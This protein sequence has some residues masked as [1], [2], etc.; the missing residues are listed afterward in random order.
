[1][2]SCG[3]HPVPPVRIQKAKVDESM[4]TTTVV[5]RVS[6]ANVRKVV[7]SPGP[8]CLPSVAVNQGDENSSQSTSGAADTSASYSV[9]PSVGTLENESLDAGET[10]GDACHPQFNSPLLADMETPDED[11]PIQLHPHE[12][13]EV[14]P[15][16]VNVTN[17]F[18][19][20]Q[21]DET[22]EVWTHSYRCM[23][24]VLNILSCKP[25]FLI[26]FLKYMLHICKSHFSMRL[27]YQPVDE[28][29]PTAPEIN[30][31][32]Y[33]CAVCLDVFFQPH[34]CEPCDHIFCAP[35][36]KRLNGSSR[37]GAICPLC[38][39]VIIKCHSQPGKYSKVYS[40]VM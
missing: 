7:V 19:V 20:L 38:R 36:L 39:E 3:G 16:H 2:C 28:E 33:V 40:N 30:E 15:N 9:S 17:Q 27:Y 29:E 32:K 35:C 5:H 1:M 37:S 22:Q 8:A 4:P 11:N 34:L 25:H 21:A 31:D 18:D 26:I 6:P 24:S 14:S 13:S 10:T 12:D 23:F